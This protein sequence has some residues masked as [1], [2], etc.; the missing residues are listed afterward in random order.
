MEKVKVLDH[1]YVAL[2]ES[3]GSD[4]RIVEAARMST[5]KG[6]QG[7]GP[8]EDGKPGDEKLLKYLYE[9]NHCYDKNTE[10]LT[11]RGF[12]PWP[13][14]LETDLLGQWDQEAC[15]LVY[16][17]P[18]SLLKRNYN[19]KMYRVNHGGVDLLVTDKH[20]MLV[21]KK[22]GI[23]GKNRQEWA[24]KWELVEADKLNNLSTIRYRKHAK[25]TAQKPVSLSMF[26][27][28]SNR[29]SLLS[30]IGFFIGDGSAGGTYANAISFHLKKTRKVNYLKKTC[31]EL[32]WQLDE[33]GS[34]TF[35]IRGDGLTKKF[36]DLF[37]DANGVKIV[38]QF[39][40]DLNCDDAL[41]ILS[42]FRE[43]DGS[44]KRGAWEYFTT[45]PQVAD[46]V[47]LIVLHAGGSAKISCNDGYMYR[48]M[49]HSRMLEPVINRGKRDTSW[50][51]YD[52]MVY[53]AHT[54]TG[55]LVV[56][57]NG[58]IVL[59]GNCTPFEMAGM[60]IEVQ[61]PIFVFREWHR[62]RSQSYNELSGRYTSIP[63]VNYVPTLDR[64]MLGSDGKNKQ[65]GTIAGAGALT[66]DE[67]ESFRSA[68][69]ESY[70]HSENVYQ[71]ALKAGVPKELARVHLPVGR[72]SRMRASSNLRNWLA[73]MTLRMAGNAQWEIR[74]YANEV[75]NLIRQKFPR[76]HG[77]F[78]SG[79][80]KTKDGS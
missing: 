64:L 20:K 75:S 35:I 8:K 70:N 37:Y 73:F 16:E 80:D 77:L 21:K 49:I 56:R 23:P 17:A 25:R 65:A 39:L 55:I 34:N 67:A 43:S 52:G 6:F 59:S 42:G 3:W 11:Q 60:I 48:V 57:R 69:V 27:A 45:S 66:V 50:E 12:V 9:N 44:V 32:G 22:V 41:S 1:G 47:Q 61:A 33:M 26:P 63:D 29:N 62:H 72:Y 78:M 68:L 24:L 58:K 2:V 76:T 4:E 46:A 14:V 15:S 18:R 40:L 7:W 19:G 10:V 54:R 74:Q 51:T 31:L 36:K 28:H 13:M 53:C 5:D 79:F 30:L 71:K 38:P